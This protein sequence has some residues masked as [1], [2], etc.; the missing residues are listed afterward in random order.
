[1]KKIIKIV[2]PL[3]VAS[4]ALLGCSSSE[5]TES[6]GDSVN[7]SGSSTVAPI[8]TRVA[9]LWVDSGSDAVVNVDG[10]GTGDGF[11]LFCNGETDISDASREIKEEE[12][13][14][15]EE[16]GI[17][18]VELKIAFD[19]ITVMTNPANET[20]ECLNFADMYSLVGPEAEGFDSWAD[21]SDLASELESDT[22]LPDAPLDI[23]GP[24]EESG[25]YDSFV[26]IVIE[27]LGEDRVEEAGQTR[28]D[29]SSSSDDNV[30]IQGVQG[31]DTSFGWVGFA[32]AEEASDSVKEIPVAAEVGGECVEP[33]IETIADGS[34]P[35][36]RPL[37][38]YVNT[39]KATSGSAV[40]D[41]VDYYLSDE[42]IAA[43]SEVGYVNLPP[44]QI[45]ETRTAW[46]ER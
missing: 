14:S 2:A 20:I 40:A 9:E 38:I 3:L 33:S 34:Y 46:T 7:V 32:F 45:E 26:E 29:Y 15:C 1:M 21:A 24:G 17:N 44:E 13:A 5:D 11:Q 30:I 6:A 42:G 8:S 31:S 27:P 18:Y 10:P 25:T 22:A 23:Y 35:I 39:D 36:S 43:V 16:N 12:I 41:Y 37:F 4:V 28:A 19:G